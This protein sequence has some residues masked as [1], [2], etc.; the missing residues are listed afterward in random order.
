MI[1]SYKY[2]IEPN[3]TQAAALD[4][5]LRDFCQ[6]YNAGLEQR[7]EAYRRQHI[8]VTYKMQADEL[9]A[10]RC[11]A[12][13]LARWSFSAEQQVLRRLDKTFKAFFAGGHGFPRFRA[14]AR[15]H[16][17]EFR[18]GDGLTLRKSG[19]IGFV[20]VP[21]EIKVR[22]HR[23]LPS[24]PKS[25]ILTRQGGKWYVVFHVEVAPVERAGPDSVGI[26]FGLSSLVAL[27]NGK[28]EPR[29]RLTKRAE[30]ELRRRQRAVA[31]CKRGSKRRAKRKAALAKFQAHVAA[32]RRDHLHNVSRDLVDRFG[33][34]AI[35]D[36]NVKGLARSV[37]AKH[38]ADASWGQLTAML[39][40][41]AANAGVELVRVDP[42]G[43]SQ[44]CPECGIIA[45]KTLDERRHLCD[46]GADIDRDVAAAMVVHFRAFG[47]W[48]G[49]GLGSLSEPVAA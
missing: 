15:F 16:A 8:S 22:W 29:Q 5:M 46:C 28:T 11:A 18:V 19:K 12:P 41:K 27:S 7:I 25:A 36:L 4:D 40:Y 33:R 44:T 45:A 37:L 23:E 20:G 2:R 42:R 6:L 30:R 9:K 48:P 24:K 26:D 3:Q 34:I 35:E 14:S 1:L 10:V 31:R 39:D 17:A 43:T 47:F 38:V 21:G 49:S 13:D 32:K